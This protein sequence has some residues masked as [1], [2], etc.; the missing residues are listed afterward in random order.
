LSN[1]GKGKP[2]G[3]GTDDDGTGTRTGRK[4]RPTEE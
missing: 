2:Y 4:D 1:L 3:T